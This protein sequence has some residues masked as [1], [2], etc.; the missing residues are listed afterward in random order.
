MQTN[1][2]KQLDLLWLHLITISRNLAKG[3]KPRTQTYI[4]KKQG[5]SH[6]TLN[7]K[8]TRLYRS[9]RL[10]THR[11][12]PPLECWTV[13]T[14]TTEKNRWGPR[15]VL[16]SAQESG[17]AYTCILHTSDSNTCE[18][19]FP[20]YVVKKKQPQIMVTCCRDKIGRSWV[21]WTAIIGLCL[22]WPWLF[23]LTHLIGVLIWSMASHR[24]PDPKISVRVAGSLFEKPMTLTRMT[25]SYLVPNFVEPARSLPKFIKISTNLERSM[26]DLV[27]SLSNL[28]KSNIKW[29]DRRICTRRV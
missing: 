8:N 20:S 2:H 14:L 7:H 23:G 29:F 16:L 12:W 4:K 27:R 25:P 1:A 5:R 17:A 22:L 6:L 28:V 19:R 3:C 11:R 13:R 26:I 9:D 24:W 18:V 15:P 21:G 10:I